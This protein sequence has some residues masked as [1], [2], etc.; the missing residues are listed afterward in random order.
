MVPYNNDVFKL[1]Y[2][3]FMTDDYHADSYKDYNPYYKIISRPAKKWYDKGKKIK[4]TRVSN[5]NVLSERYKVQIDD[6]M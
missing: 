1:S 4:I 6:I 3:D 2:Y 5:S